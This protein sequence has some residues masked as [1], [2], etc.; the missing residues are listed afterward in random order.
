MVFNGPSVLKHQA[1]ASAHHRG[2][3]DVLAWILFFCLS[4]VS[5]RPIPKEQFATLG[6][7]P[8]FAVLSENVTSQYFSNDVLQQFVHGLGEHYPDY[9]TVFK[10]GDSVNGAPIL[11]MDIG[12]AAGDLYAPSN[13]RVYDHSTV[14]SCAT[15]YSQSG[16]IELRSGTQQSELVT[17]TVLAA[18][19]AKNAPVRRDEKPYFLW[20]GNMHGNEPTG[21]PLL[22][23]L[24][25][26]LASSKGPLVQKVRNRMHT[27]IVPTM[28]PD[29]FK[30]A[31][32]NNA[33][34]PPGCIE[35][36]PAHSIVHAV[37]SSKSRAPYVTANSVQEPER[38]KS[39]FSRQ[40]G[41]R[42]AAIVANDWNR[43]T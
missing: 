31:E 22:L 21:R 19:Q 18:I 7:F 43:R 15:V 14:F 11:A 27:I 10:I 41:P 24:A 4:A 23:S 13:L 29:G 40:S 34:V 38:F 16:R 2:I 26:H 8:D 25:L 39:S 17:I 37:D 3:R 1:M 32:R 28:N 35:L 20:V 5:A 36:T 42:R 30:S 6:D 9:V 12:A 33:C